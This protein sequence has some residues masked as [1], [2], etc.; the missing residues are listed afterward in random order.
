M[1]RKARPRLLADL[2]RRPALAAVIAFLFFSQFL[3]AAT[4]YATATSRAVHLNDGDYVVICTADGFKL[5]RFGEDDTPIEHEG[6]RC[7]MGPCCLSVVGDLAVTAPSTA[8]V[9]LEISDRAGGFR[10]DPKAPQPRGPRLHGPSP[11]GPP[12]V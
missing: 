8:I 12:A 3:I 4:D 1:T 5:V 10:P 2:R 6:N 11:R 7:P 9:V